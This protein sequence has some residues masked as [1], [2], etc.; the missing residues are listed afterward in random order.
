[1]AP[2]RLVGKV[3]ELPTDAPAQVAFAVP[4]RGMRLAVDRNRVKRL[5]REAYRLEKPGVLERLKGRTGQVAWLFIY[6]GRGTPTL[7]EARW[8]ISRALHRW[9]DEHE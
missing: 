4:K 1:M 2:F 9:L 7:A 5:M 8:K 3:M 6:Q